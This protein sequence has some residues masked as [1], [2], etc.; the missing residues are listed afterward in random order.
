[1]KKN[2]LLPPTPHDNDEPYDFPLVPTMVR[3][4][5]EKHQG[6][7]TLFNV[8][9][10]QKYVLEYSEE[11]LAAAK[12]RGSVHNINNWM[13]QPHTPMANPNLKQKTVKA[14]VVK[15]PPPLC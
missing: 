3:F 1:M 12:Q 11:C 15:G 13:K 14:V 2:P 4:D 5:P 7:P 10:M 9:D 6:E 8:K